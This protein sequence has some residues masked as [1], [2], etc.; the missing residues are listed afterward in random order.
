MNHSLEDIGVLTV[1]LDSFGKRTLP[2]IFD[3]KKMIDDGG[4]LSDSHIDFLDEAL[5]QAKEYGSYVDTHP[6]FRGL[7]SRVAHLYKEITAKALENEKLIPGSIPKPTVE[8][9]L[10]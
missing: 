4:T 9:A 10:L 8:Q 7:F 1:V 3:I 2:R 5:T 6:A